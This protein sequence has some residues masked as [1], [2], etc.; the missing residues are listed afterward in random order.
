LVEAGR[1]ENPEGSVMV[2]ADRASRTG[3]L[4]KVLDQ[5]RQAG[6]ERVAIAADEPGSQ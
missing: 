5:V 1:A 4:V 2:L 6:V 3:I